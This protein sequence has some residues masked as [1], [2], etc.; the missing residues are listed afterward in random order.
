MGMFA[1]WAFE[2]SP[3][4]ICQVGAAGNRTRYPRGMYEV[5]EMS[6]PFGKANLSGTA[7]M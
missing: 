4:G 2:G 1:E 3:N 7:I 5:H 6:G